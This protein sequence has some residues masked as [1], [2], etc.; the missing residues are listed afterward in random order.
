MF[1]TL[2]AATLALTLAA[3]AFAGPPLP[4]D[5]ALQLMARPGSWIEADGDL[6]PDGTL[7]AKEVEIYSAADSAELE[8]AAIYGATARLDAAKSILRVLGYTVSFDDETTIKDENKKPTQ[9]STVRE[10]RGIKVQ[11]SLQ[12]NGTFAATKI[13]L[14]DGKKLNGKVDVKEKVF[15]PVTVV[16]ARAGTLRVLNTPVKLRPDATLLQAIVRE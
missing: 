14:Q 7:L 13:K 2:I 11:G 1:N 6:Q 16:D 15:G 9:I 3:P 8:E 10:G 4:R 5:Q 12:E